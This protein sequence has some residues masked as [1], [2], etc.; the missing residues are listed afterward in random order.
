M[1]E[2]TEK[3]EIRKIDDAKERRAFETF[4]KRKRWLS[5][6]NSEVKNRVRKDPI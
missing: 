4:L 1:R 2:Q 5:C 3:E 6:G